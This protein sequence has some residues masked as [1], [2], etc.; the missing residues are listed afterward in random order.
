[1]MVSLDRWS[2][3]ERSQEVARSRKKSQVEQSNSR[4]F[5]N[6]SIRTSEHL[7]DAVGITP[8]FCFPQL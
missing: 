6:S 7:L 1:M 5:K 3:Q 2:A 8:A 4:I